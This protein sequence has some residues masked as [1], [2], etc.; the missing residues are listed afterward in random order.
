MQGGGLQG[1]CASCGSSNCDC[2]IEVIGNREAV[3]V[4]YP[5]LLAAICRIEEALNKINKQLADITGEEDP[6]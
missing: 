6:L 3:A 5:A 2:T 1:C 4:S